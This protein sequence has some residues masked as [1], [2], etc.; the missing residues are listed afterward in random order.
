MSKFLTIEQD[1][2]TLVDK[3][4]FSA[5]KTRVKDLETAWDQSAAILKA[6]D[7]GRW[8]QADTAIDDVLHEIRS[9][10]P[11]QERKQKRSGK[12]NVCAEIGR[13]T[14]ESVV[15]IP[16]LNPNQSLREIV[17]RNWELENQIILVDD[18][19]DDEYNQIFWELSEKCIVLHH[20]ENRGKGEAIKT[21]LRYI[22]EELWQCNVI[23]IMDADGQHLA[24]DMEKLLLKAH[25]HPQALILGSRVI[26]E[27]VPWKSRLGNKAAKRV[28]C[29]LTG[30]SVSDTQTGLRAFSAKLLDFM[31]GIEGRRY[32]YEMNMLVTCAKQKIEII[33]V[34]IHTI[35]HDKN[36]SCS[37][38]RKV[39]DS[40]Q[41]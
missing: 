3:G 28:F 35:Y 10:K 22:K 8:S 26:D 24:D 17:E 4:D 9:N 23:G 14:M 21:A 20:K 11:N 32:E 40:I 15:I 5:A 25:N 19:S 1:V 7:K 13:R 27:K 36:N 2:L 6:A 41:V 37:H 16:A 38:F 33:E 31:L 12:F 30:I 18:G 29:L 39:R 34:P